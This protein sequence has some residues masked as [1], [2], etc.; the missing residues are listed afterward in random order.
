MQILLKLME[1]WHKTKSIYVN[2]PILLG[3]RMSY[4]NNLDGHARH[5]RLPI[6]NTIAR[7]CERILTLHVNII[8]LHNAANYLFVKQHIFYCIMM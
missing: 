5:G 7:T 4:K 2:M 6:A 3:P 8:I 1:K